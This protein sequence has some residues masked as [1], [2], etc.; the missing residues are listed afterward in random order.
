MSMVM[1]GCDGGSDVTTVVNE[2]TLTIGIEGE[3]TVFPEEGDHTFEEGDNVDL[4]VQPADNWVFEGWIGTNGNDVVEDNGD[5]KI[6][7]NGNKEIIA[8]FIPEDTV[9]AEYTLTIGIEGE[10][11][12]LPKEGDHTFEEEDNVDLQVQPADNWVFEGW[13]GNDGNDV[14]EDNGDYKIY[15]NGNKEIIA[16]FIPEDGEIPEDEDKY[17]ISGYVYAQND[18]PLQGIKINFNKD[19]TS[20]ETDESGYWEKLGLQGT[21][22]VSAEYQN[23]SFSP[24]MI[25]VNAP[26]DNV[27]FVGIELEEWQEGIVLFDKAKIFT[28]SEAD[29]IEQVSPARN[30]LTLTEAT[31]FASQLQVGD[32][33]IVDQPVPNA[34][35]GLLKRITSISTDG[36]TL[37]LVPATL[38]E[39]IKEGDISI[40]RTFS[41]EEMIASIEKADDIRVLEVDREAKILFFER[42]IDYDIFGDNGTISG[43]IN[44]YHDSEF[45]LDLNYAWFVPVGIDEI[46]MLFS[47]GIDTAVEIEVNVESSVEWDGQFVILNT[48]LVP[49]PGIPIFLCVNINPYLKLVAGAEAEVAAEFGAGIGFERGFEMGIRKESG[50]DWSN[51]GVLG[52]TGEGYY[53]NEPTLTGRAAAKVYS[54]L[55]LDLM[56]GVSYVLE[57][58]LSAGAYGNLEAEAEMQLLPEWLWHY[59]L[60]FFIDARL[61]AQLNILRLASPSYE[62]PRSDLYRTSLA[63]GISGQIVDEDGVGLSNVDIDFSRGFSS[64]TTNEDG[65]W[66]KHLLNGEVAITPEKNLY[67]FEPAQRTV[68]GSESSIN[69]EAESLLYDISGRVVD[70][71]DTGL[72]GVEINF[73]GGFSSVT[74]DGN[75]DWSKEGLHGDVTVAPAHSGYTFFPARRN[76]SEANQEVN[77]TAIELVIDYQIEM[78]KYPVTDVEYYPKDI[79]A[80]NKPVVNISLSDAFEYCNQLSR[81][82]GLEEAYTFN[83][84]LPGTD[85]Y[86]PH[87]TGGSPESEGYRIPFAHEWEYIARGGAI[88]EDTRYAGSDDLNEVAWHRYNLGKFPERQP[89]G[90]KLPNELG[91]YDMNGNVR[92]WVLPSE[93]ITGDTM[94]WYPLHKGGSF[95]DLPISGLFELDYISPMPSI[96]DEPVFNLKN[97]Y[98]GFRVIRTVT[99]KK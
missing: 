94:I 35:Y 28:E 98:T 88:G 53:V 84:F 60:D 32:I 55:E 45:S 34:E 6:Y 49:P 36:R 70:G 2:H 30:E 62:F 39:V 78:A 17:N 20:V 68:S 1:T 91:I 22:E 66:S 77:F 58:G 80:T 93:Y 41:F 4:Q 59:D 14:E 29:N 44:F 74:T 25:E 51:I 72:S 48:P 76:V 61:A 47:A 21:V 71:S 90:G 9:V 82:N 63:Y 87:W 67:I 33:I 11:A 83:E 73:T 57:G 64:V 3:G 99:G 23:Y 37:S 31:T 56:V 65:K 86:F 97:S 95:N 89:V 79:T 38:A 5:Y 26:R 52:L 50:D 8:S 54:G 92:E 10:G 13:F 46:V 7:M 18:Q 19:F 69:F 12:V 96:E 85:A 43:H 42:E 15:M 24:G 27:N 75:G 40:D 16:R 81:Q